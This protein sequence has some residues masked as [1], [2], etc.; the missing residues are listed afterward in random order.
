MM[1][2]AP[3]ATLDGRRSMSRLPWAW[4]LFALGQQ[5]HRIFGERQQRS[6]HG[7]L[8]CRSRLPRHSAEETTKRGGLTPDEA[9]ALFTREHVVSL[10][11]AGQSRPATGEI[12]QRLGLNFS[13]R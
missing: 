3:Q 9:A 12:S 4:P 7:A 11:L 5:G 10:D 6:E 1:A 13:L 2:T 8:C